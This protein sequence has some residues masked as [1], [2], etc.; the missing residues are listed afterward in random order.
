MGKI[1]IGFILALFLCFLVAAGYLRIS[2]GLESQLETLNDSLRVIR[3][4]L[5]LLMDQQ[6][7]G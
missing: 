5:S 1:F 6:C 7:K 2:P 4:Q 3:Q